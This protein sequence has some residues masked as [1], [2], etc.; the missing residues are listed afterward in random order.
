MKK[1]SLNKKKHVDN[2]S[3]AGY[4]KIKGRDYN[5]VHY[6]RTARSF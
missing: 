1:E 3:T 5:E 4:N 2:E 6:N